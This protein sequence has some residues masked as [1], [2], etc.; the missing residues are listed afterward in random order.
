MENKVSYY[1]VVDGLNFDAA[2]L[3]TADELVKGQGDGRISIEDSNKLLL[4]IFDGRTIT[5]VE[6]RTILYIL[7]NYKLT[8]EAS[9]NFLDKLIKYD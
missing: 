7:K 5:K 8:E 9:Q 2:L 6:G 4:K 3:E 1:K